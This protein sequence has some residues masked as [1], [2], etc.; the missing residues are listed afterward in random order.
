MLGVSLLMGGEAT[1]SWATV[2]ISG[3]GYRLKAAFLLQKFRRGGLLQRILLRYS[4]AL[5]T[6]I[7][8]TGVCNRHHSIEQQLCRWFLLTLDRV[9]SNELV[10]TQGLIA[11]ILGVSRE[12]VTGVAGKLQRAGII[13]YHRGR[14]TVLNRID[15]EEGACE[16]YDRIKKEFDPVFD[17]VQRPEGG[18]DQGIISFYR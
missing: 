12:S 2:Q 15:L 8:Q 4:H 13:R 16:C 6:H 17:D 10:M 1:S 7:S 11:N 9:G 3:Y 14:I 18:L 5:I